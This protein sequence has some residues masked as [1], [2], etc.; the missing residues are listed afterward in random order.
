MP[1]LLQPKAFT[2]SREDPAA[3]DRR[4]V[5]RAEEI[6]R[7][8]DSFRQAATSKSRQHTL[9]IG[10]RGAGKSH[11]VE[12]ALHR[13]KGDSELAE[14]FCVARIPEDAVGIASAAD[15]LVATLNSLPNVSSEQQSKARLA[16][17]DRRLVDIEA[18]VTS[19][20]G[21]RVLLLV[22]ENL[23]RV[24]AALDES[25]QGDLRAWVEGN[26]NV[27]ILAAAPQLFRG[28]DSRKM[29]WFGS[30]RIEHL[31]A[32]TVA[33]GTELIKRLAS[34][35]G[36]DKLAD[37]LDTDQA[38]D[39][40]R[41]IHHLA[42]GS[43]RIWTIFASSLSIESLEALVPAVE[44]LFEQLVPYYQ[45]RLWDLSPVEQK[46]LN[47]LTLETATATA[48]DLAA[49]TGLDPAVTTT[50]LRRLTETNWVQSSKIKGTDQ[51][52]SWY[53]VREPLLRHHYQY[54]NNQRDELRLIVDLL[55]CWFSEGDRRKW[56]LQAPASSMRESY[57]ARTMSYDPSRFDSAY[58]NSSTQ[59]LQA[60]ARLW[61]T[62]NNDGIGT[63]FT[64]AVLDALITGLLE[65]PEAARNSLAKR[66]LPASALTVLNAGLDAFTIKLEDTVHSTLTGSIGNALDAVA[67]AGSDFDH[68]TFELIAACWNARANPQRAN[69]RLCDLA[70]NQTSTVACALRSKSR[71]L[72]GSENQ[73]IL[74]KA[75]NY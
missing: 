1:R 50:T 11:L 74:M 5:G 69:Q 3:L 25:G 10:S 68:P 40:L 14:S 71:L 16:R 9:L 67:K 27:L 30:F 56:L 75:Q 63:P 4:T 19:V 22:I 33:E 64:G 36:D 62:G 18:I 35:A 15:V 52:T 65:S 8:V 44:D 61:A 59:E 70:A 43:P 60:T 24:F 37:Y 13:L 49:I 57:L 23:D 32:L 42:G 31:G 53:E 45:Q 38:N 7:L 39:R 51:R 46:I 17:R 21:D 72:S 2:P 41:T 26:A 29:P 58:A 48:G 6:E 34:D 55:H 20:V 12:V 54:R 73:G 66:K 28:V 47:A